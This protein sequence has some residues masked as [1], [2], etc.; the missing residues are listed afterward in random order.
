M[1]K[2]CLFSSLG[3]M[4]FVIFLLSSGAYAE[5]NPDP[6][7]AK[8]H[9]T[10]LAGYGVTHPGWGDTKVTVETIDFIVRYGRFLTENIGSSWYRG[11]HEILIELPIHMVV[12]PDVSPMVGINFLACWT[13]TSSEKA[14][15]YFFAGG[16]PLY[17]NAEIPGLGSKINGNYQAGIGTYY[18]L[19]QGL[20]LNAEYRIH[21]ISNAGTKE[22]NDP[23][24]SSKF[25]I[26]V[27]LFN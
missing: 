2:G 13:F 23:L 14:I 20:Y 11:R 8:Y 7:I 9:W 16:G 1:T 12:S 25:L 10:Y 26:G 19:K 27:S 24:N 3:V 17:T 15:P 18:K 4:V 22:P 6:R 5:K 21:H